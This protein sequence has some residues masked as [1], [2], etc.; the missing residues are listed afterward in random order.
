M[1]GS[2]P[3]IDSVVTVRLTSHDMQ[4]AYYGGRHPAAEY[5]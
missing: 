4:N 2:I 5:R 1:A 3:I